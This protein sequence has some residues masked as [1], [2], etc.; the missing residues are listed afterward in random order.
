MLLDY[1]RPEDSDT[2]DL[3]EW[4]DGI[5][6]EKWRVYQSG[7]IINQLEIEI[8]EVPKEAENVEV[9]LT[10]IESLKKPIRTYAFVNIE[11]KGPAKR[12]VYMD[13]KTAF[14]DELIRK[15]ILHNAYNDLK[16]FERRYGNL[17]ELES[18]FVA[19]HDFGESINDSKT[20]N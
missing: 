17:K 14:R 20:E 19:I 11:G 1:S 3:F 10:P 5:A 8:I 4:N 16:S 15:R 18:V 9:I 13:T 2:H 7:R 6:A 12:G